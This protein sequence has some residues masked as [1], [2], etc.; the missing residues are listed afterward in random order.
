MVENKRPLIFIACLCLLI[1]TVFAQ[2][3]RV[4]P[5]SWWTGMHNSELQLLIHHEN[6]ASLTP[7]IDYPGVKL[8]RKISVESPN[9]LFLD[10]EIGPDAKP[11]TV[12]IEFTD[13]KRKK[14]THQYEL[15]AR[16]PGSA[17]RQGF[18]PK[19]V[20]YLITPDRFAN[21]N[22][23][24]DEVAAMTEGPNRQDPNGRHGGDLAGITQNLDYIEDMGFTQIWINPVI[25]NNQKA[26]SYHGYAITDH[27]QV[28]ARFGSNE[29]Y[30]SLAQKAKARGIGLI[31]DMIA[32]H[33]G[34]EHWWMAD[35]PSSDWLNH[36]DI[37]ESGGLKLTSHMRTT[38]QD[39]YA[40]SADQSDF[41]DGWFDTSMPDLNQQNELMANY[42][43]QNSIWWVEYA[44]L[45]G[46]RMDTYSYPDR[47]FMA[48][49]AGAIMAEYPNFNIV[50][51]E[52]S[53]DPAIVSYWQHGK[54]NQDGYE[55][56]LTSVMD[57]PIQENLATSLNNSEENWVSGWI[58]LYETL[59]KD[60]LYPDP[61][62]LVIF[63]DNH[64]MS[65]IYT[66]LN[67][68]YRLFQLGMAYIFTTRGIPQ[69]YY[70]TEILMTNPGT[71]AHGVI[72]SDFPGGWQGDAVNAFTGKGLTAEQKKAQQLIKTLLNWRKTSN[73]VAKGKLMHYA[74]EKSI[75]VLF[76]YTDDEK[77]MV[78][79]SKND[80]T[81]QLDLSRFSDMLQGGE[82]GKEIITGDDVALNGSL[83]V[84]AYSPMIISIK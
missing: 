28:D 7:G 4:E 31:M 60:F 25:E 33:A 13:G 80:E 8:V 76:R 14:L 73:A 17:E 66:R 52:W 74:P 59:A 63:P 50:G 77:V 40:P 54:Q 58:N 34:G 71:D 65:R 62:N 46:I 72:R 44:G 64:D 2:L 27:Y 1:N 61:G 83:E 82:K 22:P 29:E 69:F 51:E 70:G 57:F 68:D 3:N 12:T 20:I 19:D 47:H 23:A 6:I 30:K 49:W 84:P 45:S 39:P 81:V 38:T 75:Y 43:I 16:E 41:V 9:Y 55:S 56:H 42:L 48:Q 79:L 11:G 21:G 24:N 18:S 32:N 35:L 26:Y 53:G 78:V 36:Q 10:L 15:Q 37:Y 67:E 5:P